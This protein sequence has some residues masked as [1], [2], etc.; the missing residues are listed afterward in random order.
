MKEVSLLSCALVLCLSTCR[1][2][3]SRFPQIERHPDPWIWDRGSL[4]VLPT[5]DPGSLEPLQ[6]DL[7]SYDLS[8]LD[9]STSV[10]DLL[11]A[12][13]DSRTVWPPPSRLPPGFDPEQIME[14]GKSPGL[15]LRQLHAQGITGR[16]VGI[17]VVDAPLLVDHRE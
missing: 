2:P 13:F 5:H 3:E 14:L 8:T 15:D 12:D 1:A 16:G 7:R 9:L 11:Q 4:A 10:D 17:A 6:V